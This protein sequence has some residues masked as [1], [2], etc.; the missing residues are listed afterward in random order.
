MLKS[1]QSAVQWKSD[2]VAIPLPRT[3]LR[4]VEMVHVTTSFL[5]ESDPAP[6]TLRKYP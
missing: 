3:T 2:Q 4:T 6:K 1:T 5:R